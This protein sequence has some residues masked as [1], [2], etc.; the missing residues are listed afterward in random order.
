[1]KEYDGSL[2]IDDRFAEQLT[3]EEGR[4]LQKIQKAFIESYLKNRDQMDVEPWLNMEL[5]NQM[6]DRTPEEIS[7]MSEEIVE[8]LKTTEE[9]KK[10]LQEA[11]LNGRSREG[12]LA[13]ELLE[14]TSSM[15]AQDAA[16]YLQGLDDTLA[17]A[18]EAFQTTLKT[19][20]GQ[21]S[22]NANL[23]GFIAE[24]YHAQ[25]F[26]L[27]AEAS[28]SPYRAR[29]LEPD[30]AR[31]NKNSVDIVIEDSAGKI[32][33]RYQSKYYATAKDT[34]AASNRGD[35]RGQRL[36]V[37]SD[38][39]GDIDKKAVDV[40]Q[41]PDGTASNPLAKTTAKELQAEAQSG[42][43]NELNWNKYQA[44]DLAMGIGKQAGQA[45]LMGAAVGTGFTLASKLLNDEEIKGDELVETA[46]VSGADF[47]VKAAAAGALK[48][49]AE[50]EIIK[51]IPKGTPAGTLANIA[52]VAVE[53]V[54][55]AGRMATGELSLKDGLDQMA[56]VTTAT[57]A[58]LAA[59]AKGT[60]VGAAVGTVLGPV[61]TVVGGF[62]GGTI[63]YMAG[64]TVG[65]A[66]IDGVKKVKDIVFEGAKEVVN[67]VK[68]FAKNIPLIGRLF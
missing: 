26:N 56:R 3:P 51:V 34:V 60:A 43:W 22:Q 4:M 32:V 36:L 1:M 40:I 11:M 57:V 54:K 45:A 28:G 31:Y 9:K 17:S 48:V 41:A 5:S 64:S 49:G 21:I 46:L 12:W 30:G 15:E 67:G 25:T 27:N 53:N 8:S 61:G 58:G 52:F 68:E 33:K 66:V 55:V 47:G 24:Q 6:P 23:D 19:K 65:K 62:I 13:D 38:Q 18:N 14:A 10:N 20:A 42:K 39:I 7:Q 63:G 37:P 16:A 50:K 44:K 2:M 59:S 29:V 35:Y